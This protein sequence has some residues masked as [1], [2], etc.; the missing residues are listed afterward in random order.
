MAA[1]QI[2]LLAPIISRLMNYLPKNKSLI[3]ES[4]RN[5]VKKEISPIIEDY[6]QKAEFPATYCKTTR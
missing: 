5:Y 4:V 6:A 1:R 3:R 2:N